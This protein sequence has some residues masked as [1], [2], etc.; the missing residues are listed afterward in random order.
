MFYLCV[1]AK[2]NLLIYNFNL[3][4]ILYCVAPIV[5]YFTNSIII[6]VHNKYCT[7]YASESTHKCYKNWS[8]SSSE[9]ETDIIIFK[10]AEQT[11][12]LHYIRFIGDGDSSVRPTLLLQIPI[13]G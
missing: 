11:H 5:V 13:W 10:K 2:Q 7:Q 6:G 3:L 12:G 1:L 8:G 4:L 9:I